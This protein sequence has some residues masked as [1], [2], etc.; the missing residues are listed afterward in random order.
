MQSSIALDTIQSSKVV[1]DT[2]PQV[3][4]NNLSSTTSVSNRTNIPTH[5]LQTAIR[6]TAVLDRTQIQAPIF[7][8]ENN[9][10]DNNS[11]TSDIE[12]T[13][14]HQDDDENYLSIAE[15]NES[16]IISDMADLHFSKIDQIPIVSTFQSEHLITDILTI[17]DLVQT[18]VHD[19]DTDTSAFNEDVFDGGIHLTTSFSS[20][21]TNRVIDD[22]VATIVENNVFH[23][24][25]DTERALNPNRIKLPVTIEAT[26]STTRSYNSYPKLGTSDNSKFSGKSIQDSCTP[27]TVRFQ[28]VQCLP[29]VSVLHDS[30]PIKPIKIN[31]VPLIHSVI[32][33]K[34][35][36]SSLNIN[37]VNHSSKLRRLATSVS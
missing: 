1:V 10:T 31:D 32:L 20:T 24:T 36:S 30:P 22:S 4:L 18:E 27:R 16:S 11:I 3:N 33:C 5:I 25:D 6:N 13:N 8:T 28:E 9:K 23:E 17:N 37:S 12:V 15:I 21:G 26:N 34:T 2:I 19:V 7:Q 35:T 29:T 14:V